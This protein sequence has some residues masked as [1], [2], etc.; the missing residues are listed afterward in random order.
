MTGPGHHLTGIA[1]GLLAAGLARHF[2]PHVP[3][4]ILLAGAW[5]G[6]IAPDRLELPVWVAGRLR[7]AIP[8]RTITHWWPL[9]AVPG[10]WAAFVLAHLLPEDTPAALAWATL[11]AACG[12]L[13]HL[14]CDWP[15]PMGIPLW[16]PWRRHSLRLWRSGEREFL[17]V[18]AAFGIAAISWMA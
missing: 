7:R 1:A 14:L 10:L 2:V 4:P 17:L 13:A 8:H 3:V 5:F 11:G 15:N 12:A 6:G 16:T 9:W 18:A